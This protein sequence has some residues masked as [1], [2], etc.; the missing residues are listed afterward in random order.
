MGTAPP[1]TRWD[2][3]VMGRG[4]YAPAIGAGIASPYDHLDQYVVSTTLEPAEH[5][6]V[7]VVSEDPLGFVRRLK[8]R[9]GGDV[10]LCGG[11]SLAGVLVDEVAASSSSSTR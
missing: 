10:W 11:G 3:V 7:S 6:G 4:T 5:P 1:V 9:P 8:S 2:T